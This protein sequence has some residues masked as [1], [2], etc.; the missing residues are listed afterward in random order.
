[1]GQA[2]HELRMNFLGFAKMVNEA[3]AEQENKDQQS[4]EE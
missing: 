3:Q 2:L 1:M 4:A